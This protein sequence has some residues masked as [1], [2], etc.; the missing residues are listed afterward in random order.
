LSELGIKERRIGSVTIL[1]TD[2]LL[3]IKLRFGASSVTLE[4]AAASLLSAGQKHILL[5]LEGIN[6][7]SAK[8]LGELVST[9]VVIKNGGGQ[10][11]LFNLTPRV[12]QLMQVTNLF[13][14]FQLYETETDALDSFHGSATADFVY[15]DAAANVGKGNDDRL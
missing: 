11:K 4:N 13:A 2:A 7:I 5:S 3:R 10:F 12:R 9:Y 8:N 1:N 6:S 15:E 14:V